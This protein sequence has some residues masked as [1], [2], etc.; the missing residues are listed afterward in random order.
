MNM[1]VLI[2]NYINYQNGKLKISTMKSKISTINSLILDD[3]KEMDSNYISTMDLQKWKDKLEA[4]NNI[5]AVTKNVAISV[6]KNILLYANKIDELDTKNYNKLLFIL[7]PIKKEEIVDEEEEE[8]NNFIT[9]QQFDELIKIMNKKNIQSKKL[10][11]FITKVLF[12]TGMRKSELRG[13]K[14]NKINLQ[15]KTI[16]I[17]SQKLN[18]NV[19]KENVTLKSKNSKRNILIDDNLVSLI[20]NYIIDNKL[21]GNDYLIPDVLSSY[22]S[23]LST[24][25]KK[26]GVDKLTP[27]GLRHSHCSYLIQLYMDNNII[28][29]FGTIARRLGHNVEN[30]MNVYYHMYPQQQQKLID[31]LNK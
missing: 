26:I 5:K 21:N 12:Y 13:L 2:D 11:I 3:F 28:P 25:A 27:H 7:E 17:I 15:E 24:C 6:F 23:F 31:L 19:S 4:N 10:Y 29:D 14:V 8:L 30:T 20:S 22:A 1:K 18:S 16:S 9:K